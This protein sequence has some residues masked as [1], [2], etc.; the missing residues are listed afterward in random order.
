MLLFFIV[1]ATP[2]FLFLLMKRNQAKLAET[3]FLHKFSTIYCNLKYE[4]TSSLVYIL[5]LFYKRFIVAFTMVFLRENFNLQMI[6]IINTSLLFLVYYIVYRPFES[7]YINRIEILN[8][9]TFLLCTYL[10]FVY[11]DIL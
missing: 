5:F 3:S 11:T 7:D 8:E 10:C 1:F 6:F 9:S 2:I 4:K